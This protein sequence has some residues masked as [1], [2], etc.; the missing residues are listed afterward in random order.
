MR[1]SDERGAL[2]V[3]EAPYKWRDNFIV[4]VGALIEIGK[5]LHRIADA[6]EQKQW[7]K[8]RL[9]NV[10]TQSVLPT[11]Q[12]RSCQQLSWFHQMLV[13]FVVLH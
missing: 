3:K 7:R 1:K 11:N 6:L 10:L 5:A 2:V 12:R 4:G 8:Y 13:V 9:E